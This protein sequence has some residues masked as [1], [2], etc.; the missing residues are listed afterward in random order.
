M[1]KLTYRSGALTP[2]LMLLSALGLMLAAPAHA[3]S[4]TNFNIKPVAPKAATTTKEKAKAA[5]ASKESASKAIAPASTTPSRY[6]G[7][8][9]LAAHVESLSAAFSMKSRA[10]DPFGQYQDPDAKPIIKT[11]TNKPTQ[12]V[13][14]FQATPFSD[15]V[16]HLK[17]TTIMPG[18]K[19]FL[20]ADRS[21]KQGDRM[22]LIFR[23]KNISAQIISVGARQIDFRN[24]E[25][26]E[27]ASLKMEL[28]P[29]GM[30][31]GTKG[32]SAPGMVPANQNTPIELEPTGPSSEAS[33]QNP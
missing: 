23:G 25:T 21:F 33:T 31:P 19:R 4:A 7:E 3:Q 13:K 8:E 32:I 9:E 14:P 6:I 11:P 28:L 17:V 24:A 29:I 18:E 1:G 30:T 2:R 27:T 16:R 5:A 22:P 26:G 12:K 20:L 10:T 15:I